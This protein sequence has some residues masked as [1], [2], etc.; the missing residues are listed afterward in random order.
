MAPKPL[1]CINLRA[2]LSHYVY[3]CMRRGLA[4]MHP[5]IRF[6]SAVVRHNLTNTNLVFLIPAVDA[7]HPAPVSLSLVW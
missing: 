4:L 7:R 3:T 2:G 6:V 1:L 5:K